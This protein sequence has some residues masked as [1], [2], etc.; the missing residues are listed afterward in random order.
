MKKFQIAFL[1]LGMLV[2]QS[3][4]STRYTYT[5]NVLDSIVGKKKN[6]VLTSIGVP[7]RTMDDGKGGGNFNL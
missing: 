5:G 3:C 1:I 6:D 2:F 4:Y 7:E